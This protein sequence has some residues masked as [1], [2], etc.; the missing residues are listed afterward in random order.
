VGTG[1]CVLL[2]IIHH[3]SP[4]YLAGDRVHWFRAEVEMERWR[5]Q[6]EIK[7]VEFLRCIRS[8]QKMSETWSSLAARPS[9]QSHT[10][11]ACKKSLM[12][13]QMQDDVQ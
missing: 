5:E 11:Y 8:F 2:T 10:A 4:D 3:Q 1:R 6:W 7:L 12:Y 13:L 9:S